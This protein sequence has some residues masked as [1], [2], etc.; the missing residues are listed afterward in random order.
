MS[1]H[2]IVFPSTS[3]SLAINTHAMDRSLVERKDINV[4]N[5]SMDSPTKTGYYRVLLYDIIP[6]LYRLDIIYYS[7]AFDKWYNSADGIPTKVPGPLWQDL[8]CSSL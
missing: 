6:C 7:E 4:E 5:W 8:K 2:E 3:K 1:Y